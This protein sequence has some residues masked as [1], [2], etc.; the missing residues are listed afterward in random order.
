[1]SIVAELEKLLSEERSM[2]LAG[3]Y[4]GLEKLIDRKAQLEKRLTSGN[5]DLPSDV[6]KQVRDQAKHN[7]ALLA[8]AQRGLQSTM[9]QLRNLSTGE[10]QKTYSRD[11]QRVSMSR[12]ST[13]IAQKI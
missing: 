1:M 12:K 7:E 11:G 13:S 3:D 5:Q 2:L 4:G 9:T 6:L 10:A 8:A